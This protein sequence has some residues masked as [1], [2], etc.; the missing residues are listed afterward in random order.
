[1][2]FCKAGPES[3]VG[4][5]WRL[6]HISSSKAFRLFLVLLHS[7]FSRGTHIVFSQHLLD[8]SFEEVGNNVNIPKTIRCHSR[9]KE[10]ITPQ[11][12]ST[13]VPLVLGADG[14]NSCNAADRQRWVNAT[15]EPINTSQPS[16]LQLG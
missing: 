16:P 9:L 8:C 1:M 7:G 12:D 3:I 15:K 14:R 4:H 6:S 10:I 2:Q 11:A 5:V 13:T